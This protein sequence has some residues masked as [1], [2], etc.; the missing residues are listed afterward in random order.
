MR[1]WRA[2]AVITVILSAL[3]AMP[4]AS[5][6]VG[7]FDDFSSGRLDPARWLG[8]QYATPGTTPRWRNYGYEDWI[9]LV[10]DEPQIGDSMRRVVAGQA[11]IVL[12]SIRS[13][14]PRPNPRDLR[15]GAMARSGLRI[16][17]PALADHAPPVRTFRATVTVVEAVVSN[18]R[19][20]MDCEQGSVS[21]ARVGLYGHFFNDGTGSSSARSVTGDVFATVKLYRGDDHLVRR[22]YIH[23]VIGRCEDI[24]PGCQRI[25]YTGGARFD[26]GW[27]TDVPYVLTI[28]WQQESN[29]FTFTVAGD[30]A[31]ESRTVPYTASDVTRAK[32]YAYDLRAESEPMRCA[33]DGQAV[34]QRIV[35]DARF[36]DVHLD[37]T[38]ANA[39]R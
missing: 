38:A 30:G 5:Q 2:A 36:D 31:T 11:Q 17:H 21:R 7:L 33:L 23:A 22:N 32:I 6:P 35:I 24:E 15:Y 16:N 26:M 20:A 27:R 29:S 12:T 4:A 14:G 28:A 18:V 1:T 10:S 3:W 9:Q 19:P 34:P 8:Y 25:K 39:T 13:D 37:P